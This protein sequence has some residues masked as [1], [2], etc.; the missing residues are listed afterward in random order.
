MEG[1]N[2]IQ[3]AYVVAGIINFIAVIWWDRRRSHRRVTTEDAGLTICFAGLAA[4]T[5]F[6]SWI[7][8][9]VVGIMWGLAVAAKY[10]LNMGKPH[11]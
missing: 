8:G 4:I 6:G 9:I 3:L 2:G 1:L 5:G 11:E 10:I 7:V